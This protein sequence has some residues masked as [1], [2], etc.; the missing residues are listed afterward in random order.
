MVPALAALVLAA[1]APLPAAAQTAERC[2]AETGYCIS[3]SIRAYWER[4][5]GLAVF[6]YPISALRTETVEGSWTGPV[7]WFERDRLEDHSNEGRGVLAGR[8]GARFLELQG[9]DWQALPGDEAAAPGCRFFR[10]TQFNLCEPFLSYWE[11][12]G[13]LARFGYPI[14]RVRQETLEGREYSV[15][16]FERR[17]MEVHP[18]LP[19]GPGVLLGLLGRAVFAVEG[20]RAVVPL[21]PGDLPADVQQAIL[22]A[23]YAAARAANPRAKIA[24]GLVDVAGDYAFALAQP[25]GQ[26]PLFVYLARRGGA[27]QVVEA[28]AIPSSAILRQRGVPEQL[29]VAGDAVA[30][31][32]VLGQ[33]QSLSGTGV[34]IYGTRPRVAGDYARLWLAPG[35]SENLASGAVLFRRSGGVWRFL[36]AG[37]AFGEDELRRLGV[38]QALWPAGASVRGPTS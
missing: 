37:A 31:F 33:I 9:I 20:D 17:R 3:G 6:G 21:A 4:N 35:A 30:I 38:P 11:R 5:G 36:T 26:R 12:N 22:D 14:G 2:F 18:E 1:L 8:L 25:F 28:T 29:M 16:Y 15:Q 13:G 23:A 10:E 19:G 34:N 32:S 7:Q 27:W 24:V